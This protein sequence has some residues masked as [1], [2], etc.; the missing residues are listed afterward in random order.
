MWSVIPVLRSAGSWWESVGAAR[1]SHNDRLCKPTFAKSH[2]FFFQRYHHHQD[3]QDQPMVWLWR[4]QLK[5]SEI[6]CATSC[7]CQFKY[8][9][10][11]ARPCQC[12]NNPGFYLN[13]DFI[14]LLFG[15]RN[16]ELPQLG[17][18][19]KLFSKPAINSKCNLAACIRSVISALLMMVIATFAPPEISPQTH[20][21]GSGA[22]S[23]QN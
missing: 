8:L 6:S 5:H 9:T 2:N 16:A 15:L 19:S 21:F 18:F 11:K 23:C 3:H 7:I 22:I 17:R 13:S 20:W 10:S 12:R 14:T 1:A 4:W